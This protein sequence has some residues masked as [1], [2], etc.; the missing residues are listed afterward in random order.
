VSHYGELSPE[1]VHTYYKYGCALLYKAQEEAD[2]LADVP[3]KE[4]GSQLG[5]TKEGPVKSSVNAESS[6]ASFSSNAGQDV[7]STDQGEAVDDGQCVA[8][9]AYCLVVLIFVYNLL[10]YLV[11]VFLDH[12]SLYDELGICVKYDANFEIV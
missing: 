7:T 12:G 11:K 2:P 6:T 4:D 5:S 9:R 1:C 3:K 8:S 10:L